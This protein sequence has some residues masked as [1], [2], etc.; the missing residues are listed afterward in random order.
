ME[1]LTH[2]DRARL[3]MLKNL[4]DELSSLAASA[5]EPHAGH[6]ISDDARA[7]LAADVLQ[8]LTNRMPVLANLRHALDLAW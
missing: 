1:K 3:A 2:T 5:L 8:A 4:A 7:A 6:P